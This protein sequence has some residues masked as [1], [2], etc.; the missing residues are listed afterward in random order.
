MSLYSISAAC[1]SFPASWKAAYLSAVYK[2]DDETDKHNYRL[3]S[4]L[5][6]PGILFETAVSRTITTHM[7]DLGNSHQWAYKKGHST[8]VLL[9]KMV[10]HWRCALDTHLIVG[11]AFVE[12]RKAF[13]SPY[14]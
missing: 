5:S 7:S 13:D 3:I 8:E 2:K 12:F 1:N 14:S 11:I 6:V 9:V 10:E 4:L